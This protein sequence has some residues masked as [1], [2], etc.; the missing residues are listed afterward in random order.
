MSYFRRKLWFADRDGRHQLEQD[1]LLMRRKPIIVLGE[2][3]MGKTKLLK[4]LG[5][6]AGNAFCRAQKLINQVRT[7]P[8]LGNAKLVIDALDEVS[9]QSD[10]DAVNLVL[11]K[12]GELGYPPFILSC[13]VGEWRAAI[14]AQ[15][16]ADQYEDVPPLE[17]HLEP[18]DEDEQY[19]L[20][21]QLTGDAKRA[22]VLL[23]HFRRFGLDFLGNPQALELF[24]ALPF[25][26]PLPTTSGAL[27]EQAIEALRKEQNQFKQELPREVV[28]DAAGAAFSALILSGIARIVD[29]P[30]GTIDLADKALPLSEVEA[31][32]H[33]H[34]KQAAN[35]K[36]FATDRDGLSYAHRR[37]GEFVSARWLAA[38]ADTRT[39]RQRLLQQFRS[40]G[41][42]PAS[43]RGLHAGWRATHSWQTR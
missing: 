43:L 13:R 7:E 40:H 9:A 41:L 20:L 23:D 39:K 14:S 33:G 21:T 37:I 18:L 6:K 42:V 22:R 17:V 25:D 15:A 26:Q 35:T 38:R 11:R 4:E 28:L 12:L 5:A 16:I 8:L 31:F 10:G 19:E 27:F 24:A 32:D 36:L 29:Q 34:V 30:S 2:P 3:G 1:D